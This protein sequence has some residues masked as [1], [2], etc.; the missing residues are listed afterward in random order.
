M[1]GLTM[2]MNI[3]NYYY[4]INGETDFRFSLTLHYSAG[5]FMLSKKKNSHTTQVEGRKRK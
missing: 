2:D 3:E 5:S 1:L 4:P